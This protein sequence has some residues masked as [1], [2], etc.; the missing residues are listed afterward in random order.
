MSI[1]PFKSF[2][3]SK[4]GEHKPSEIEE[5]ILDSL[6][7]I[8]S[9][10]NEQ[11]EYLEQYTNLLHLSLNDIGIETLD[12]FPKI[13]SLQVL[14]IMNNNLTGE[15]LNKMVKLYPSLYKI[16]LSH[17][18]ISNMNNIIGGIKHSNIEKI[19]ILGNPMLKGISGYRRE[20]FNKIPKLKIIDGKNIDE[21]SIDTTE[22][23]DEE[24]TS[25]ENDSEGDSDFHSSEDEESENDDDSS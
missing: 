4:I 25:E 12:N 23:S 16:K 5:L 9:F 8:K 15:D 20:L 14:E 21:F 11:K 6:F 3:V 17:N 1:T 7:K 18:K 10:N 13:H 22:Y 19:E 24:E 2:I